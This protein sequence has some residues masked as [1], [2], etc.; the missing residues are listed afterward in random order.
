MN[1]LETLETSR[2]NESI[3]S[4]LPVL[5][6]HREATE[7][8]RSVAPES[9][10]ALKAAGLARLLT[11]SR[12]GGHGASLRAQL[13]ACAETARACPA[14]SWVMMV[15]GAHNWIAGNFSA[16]C[17]AEMFD[18]DPDLFIAGTLASQGTFKKA[19][20][21]WLLS[22]RWQFCSGVDH[23]PW[24]LIGALRAKDSGGGPGSLHVMLPRD[25]VELD[26]TWHTLGMRGSGSKDVVLKDVFV[27]E[28]RAEA[29]GKLFSGRSPHAH[30][31]EN[32]GLY[33][34]PVLCSLSAQLAGAVLGMAREMLSL[35]IEKTSVRPDIYSGEGSGAKARRGTMQRRVAEA[36]GEISTAELILARNCDM[37]DEITVAKEP[38]DEAAQALLRWQSAYAVELCRRAVE[39]LYAGAG[40]HAAYN[41]SPMQQYYR[42]VMMA[43]HHAA[44][45]M[46]GA[47]E[48]Q[49]MQLLGVEPD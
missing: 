17:R 3:Q 44:V 36:S 19:E 43:T 7:T 12:N 39:R 49:G 48:L 10:A 1:A 47:A 32:S 38:V 20:G 45:D 34:V 15:C 8:G 46:D 35:F 40:A 26:D 2:Y 9:I 14:S 5:A 28:H 13:H 18:A 16:R 27:P 11:P 42:D 33:M 22:G 21:G 30:D 24:L 37:F 31:H 25:Q 41:D 6:A 29:T 23:S 4:V